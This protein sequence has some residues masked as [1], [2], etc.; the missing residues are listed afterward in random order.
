[1]SPDLIFIA[2]GIIG[3]AVIIIVNMILLKSRNHQREFRVPDYY[4]K[5][6]EEEAKINMDSTLNPVRDRMIAPIQT[7]RENIP[8]KYH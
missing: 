1:M 7:D 5:Q 3:I 6:Y 8:Q 4:F 2:I